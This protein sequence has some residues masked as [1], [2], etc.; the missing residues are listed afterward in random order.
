MTAKS[1]EGDAHGSCR[2]SP[3]LSEGLEGMSD[4]RRGPFAFTTWRRHPPN[5]ACQSRHRSRAPGDLRLEGG[6][7]RSVLC[8]CKGHPHPR[9]RQEQW[10]FP[11]LEGTLPLL[12][13]QLEAAALFFFFFLNNHSTLGSSVHSSQEKQKPPLAWGACPCSPLDAP[14]PILRGPPGGDTGPARQI[15][16]EPAL[17]QRRSRLAARSPS[18]QLPCEHGKPRLRELI[19]CLRA[20]VRA[21]M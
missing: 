16:G 9:P 21:Q 13:V 3:H 5:T 20:Y 7:R 15:R 8:L 11:G 4:Q 2:K 17:A 12:S 1:W 19:K 6:T 10:D 18:L 14:A